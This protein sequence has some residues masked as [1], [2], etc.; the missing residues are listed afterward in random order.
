MLNFLS[1]SFFLLFQ[2]TYLENIGE[3]PQVE[4]VVELDS[5]GGE[6]LAQRKEIDD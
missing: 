3:I 4:Y 6:H 5:C 1:P 2:Q